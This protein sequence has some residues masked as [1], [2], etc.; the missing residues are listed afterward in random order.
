VT[1]RDDASRGLLEA[2]LASLVVIGLGVIALLGAT[3][4]GP[5]AGYVAVGPAVMPTI[6][7]FGLVV[8]GGIL[9]VRTTVR[10]DLDLARRVGVE[11]AASEWRTPG[12]ILGALVAYAAALGPIGYIPATTAFLP[13][14]A[15]ILGSRR[16]VRD[17]LVAVVLSVVVFIGFTEFLGVRLPAGLLDPIL[18]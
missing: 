10:P 4:V 3:Q 1:P 17:L 7:G 9:L 14:A 12:L 13:T 15:A 8:L 2:R 5:G 11:A 18:P 6:I 16:P